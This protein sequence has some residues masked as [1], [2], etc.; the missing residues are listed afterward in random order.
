MPE[1]QFLMLLTHFIEVIR[2][3]E[4]I[5]WSCVKSDVCFI[6]VQWDLCSFKSFEI[7]VIGNIFDNKE[8]LESEE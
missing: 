2:R 6:G 5:D 4:T 7:E 1:M 8:L 3:I